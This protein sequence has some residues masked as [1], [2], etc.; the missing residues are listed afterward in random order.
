VSNP[1][2]RIGRYEVLEPIGRGGMGSLYLALDPLLDRQ[3]AI[4]L[5]RDDDDELRERFAREARAAARLR[6]PNIVTIFDVGEHDGQPF[7]AMEYIQG[8]TLAEIVRGNVPL[9]LTRKLELIEALCDGLGFAHRSGIVHRDI[10]PAN[11]MIDADGS[12][13]ILDFGIAR[14]AESSGMTQ[15]GMLIGTLNY[16]SPE[17]VSGQPVDARSDLFAVGAV[18]YELLTYRQAFPGGLMAGV[19]NRILSGQPD[20]ITSIVP[21]LDP[22]IVAIVERA[23]QKEPD[24]RYQDL[25]AMR[26]DI[27]A[28]RS[29]LTLSGQAATVVVPPPA[30]VPGDAPSKPSSSARR[31]ADLEEIGRRRNEQI[32]RHLS[33]AESRLAAGEAEAAIALAEQAL[34]LDTGHAKAHEVIERARAMVEARQ[35]DEALEADWRAATWPQRE[36][37][38][39]APPGS[40]LTRPECR[41]CGDRSRT[42]L[43]VRRRRG[44]RKRSTRGRARRSTRRSAGSRQAAARRR[45]RYWPASSRHTRSWRERSSGCGPKLR[46]TPKKSVPKRNAPNTSARSASVSGSAW[47]GNA[48][49][50]SGRNRRRASDRRPRRRRARHARRLRRLTAASMPTIR[51]S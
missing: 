22:D 41:R 4:K 12:L 32:Q 28:V 16:M 48:S 44:R 21:D 8:Q 34:L 7:I 6:H 3:I 36:S 15:A 26:Q 24:H 37:T 43:S 25:G 33:E 9:T 39:R 45:W 35:L 2:T 20:P 50:G 47:N 38:W 18:F 27:A 10:K 17:Q 13:K 46:A 19:L 29:R 14:A 49:R 30:A 5:L 42:R 11:L 40:I 23:L 31:A 51:R 1:P